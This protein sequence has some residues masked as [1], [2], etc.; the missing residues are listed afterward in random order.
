MFAAG[1]GRFSFYRGGFFLEGGVNESVQIFVAKER[2]HIAG[3]P[4]FGPMWRRT[5]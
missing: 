3:S 5:N 2:E 4:A 1:V